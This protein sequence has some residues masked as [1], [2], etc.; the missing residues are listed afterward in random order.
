MSG[1]LKWYGTG[2]WDAEKVMRFM[3]GKSHV[4]EVPFSEKKKKKLLEIFQE[5]VTVMFQSFTF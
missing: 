1:Y 3:Y 2:R 5:T 4:L